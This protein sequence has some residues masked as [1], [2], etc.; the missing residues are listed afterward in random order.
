VTSRRC[1]LLPIY[2]EQ[3]LCFTVFVLRLLSHYIPVSSKKHGPENSLEGLV[4][5]A[6]VDC[7]SKA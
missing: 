6:R 5:P 3:L 2:F 7:L 1:G 4:C